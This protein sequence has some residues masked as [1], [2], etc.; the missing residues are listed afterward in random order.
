M[1]LWK[2][3]LLF[4]FSAVLACGQAQPPPSDAGAPTQD[5][6]VIDFGAAHN[7]AGLGNQLWLNTPH[8]PEQDA[9]LKALHTRYVRVCINWNIPLN[10]LIA[11]PRLSVGDLSDL[12][13][14]HDVP[15]LDKHVVDFANEMKSLGTEMHFVFFRAPKC[16]LTQ[17]GPKSW[18]A[19]PEYFEDAANW[20][21]AQLL[22]AKTYGLVPSHIEI[23]NEPEGDWDARYTPE[24]Y[25]AYLVAVRNAMDANG[26]EQIKIAGPGVGMGS[27]PTVPILTAVVDHDDGKLLDI[28]SIHCYDPTIGGNNFPRFDLLKPLMARLTPGTQLFVTEYNTKAHYWGDPPY[29]THA[30]KRGPKNG[31]DSDDFAV[32]SVGDGL[33]VIAEGAN[34]IFFWEASDQPWEN[35]NYGMIN[36]N[37]KGKPVLTAMKIAFPSLPWDVP[38]VGAKGAGEGLVAVAFKTPDGIRVAM[39]NL[40]PNPHSITVNFEGLDIPFRQAGEVRAFDAKAGENAAANPPTLSNGVLTDDLPPRTLVS[41]LLK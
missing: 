8:Q 29:E 34:S 35:S 19:N 14:K 32:S 22:Q 37:G 9:A 25:D 40:T 41:F 28:L 3:I 7:F 16:W 11:R 21:T 4:A 15:A 20:I 1:N 33:K 13:K 27:V 31:G 2:P 12:I 30:G 10:E 23:T 24:Q 39:V 36:L 18:R 38:A 6:L 17:F 26:L 5:H